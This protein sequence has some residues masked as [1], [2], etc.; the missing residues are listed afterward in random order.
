MSDYFSP[1]AIL[2]ISVAVLLDIAGIL[3]AILIPVL[4]IGVILSFIPDIVGILFFGAWML[5]RGQ[6]TEGIKQEIG[7]RVDQKRK[8]KKAAKGLKKGMKFGKFGLATLGEL[9]PVVGAL[10]FWTIFVLLEL[11]D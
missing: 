10:P 9:I 2:V 4:G 6:G 1:E 8:L 3:C 5:F 11:R 7:E